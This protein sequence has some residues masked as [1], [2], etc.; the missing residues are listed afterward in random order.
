MQKNQS[1]TQDSPTLSEARLSQSSS[2]PTPVLPRPLR[3][4]GN[5]NYSIGHY[6]SGPLGT[7]PNWVHS[8]IRNL[9]PVSTACYTTETSGRLSV[10]QQLTTLEKQKH[11][12]TPVHRFRKLEAHAMLFFP[13]LRLPFTPRANASK[14]WKPGCLQLSLSWER[15]RL[16]EGGFQ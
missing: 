5:A 11:E 16:P 3:S 13:E 9:T 15:T 12:A 1:H 4:L 7:G 14:K 6:R 8:N 10:P 2:N